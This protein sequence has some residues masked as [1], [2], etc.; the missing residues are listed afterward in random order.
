MNGD[1]SVNLDLFLIITKRS[2]TYEIL[3]NTYFKFDT[4]LLFNTTL[5]EILLEEN[6]F[7]CVILYIG[8]I[9]TI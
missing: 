3:H 5:L 4:K 2:T 1:A 7:P 8:Y 9:I 6:M